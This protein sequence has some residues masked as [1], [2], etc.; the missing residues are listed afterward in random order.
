MDSGAVPDGSTISTFLHL[1]FS[2]YFLQSSKIGL[3]ETRLAVY[4]TVH[5]KRKRSENQFA[6]MQNKK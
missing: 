4:A 6:D 1:L 5:E 3:N 2:F